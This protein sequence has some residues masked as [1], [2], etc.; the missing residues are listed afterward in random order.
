MSGGYILEK[1]L[2][3]K[4]LEELAVT[5]YT[6]ERVWGAMCYSPACPGPGEYICVLCNKKTEHISGEFFL[7]RL[8]RIREIISELKSQGYDVRLDEREFC[9]YCNVNEI[10]YEPKPF[11]NIRFDENDDYQASKVDFHSLKLLQAFLLGGDYFLGEYDNTVPLH[12]SIDILSKMTGFCEDMADEWLH[13]VCMGDDPI[14]DS[15]RWRSDGDFFEDM[16]DDDE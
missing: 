7:I 6:G 4:R 13:K 5:P 12:E 8:N 14:Y 16:D 1:K 9:Q 3:E 15:V 2:L 11:L 10:D